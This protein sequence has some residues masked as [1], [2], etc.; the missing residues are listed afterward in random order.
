[1]NGSK[2]INAYRV[3]AFIAMLSGAM[4]TTLRLPAY[5]QQEVDPTWYD[6][7][8]NVVANAVPSTGPNAVVVHFSQPAVVFHRHE[9]AVKS[10]SSAEGSGKSRGKQPATQPK[11][12]DIGVPRERS[13]EEKVAAIAR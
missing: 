13:Q 6:P 1:M 11:I 5:G 8:P 2:G 3:L 4:V 12:A 10:M 7:A 9:A